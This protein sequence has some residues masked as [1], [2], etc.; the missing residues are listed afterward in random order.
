MLDLED[1]QFRDFCQNPLAF[2]QKY[3]LYPEQPILWI[4]PCAKPPIGKGIPKPTDGSRWTVLIN[5]GHQ[6]IATCAAC[7]QTT[8]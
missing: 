6:S 5:H 4:S 7:P 8:Q 1:E 3:N 2:A